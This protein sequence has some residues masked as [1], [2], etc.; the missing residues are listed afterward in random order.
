[1]KHLILLAFLFSAPLLSASSPTEIVTEAFE[2]V[3]G[4]KPD[5]SGMRTFRSRVIEDGWTAVDVRNALKRSDEYANL[6]ITRSFEDVL[7]RKPDQGALKT[8]R[9]KIKRGWTEQDLR[10]VLRNSEEYR[11]RQGG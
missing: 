8:Y 1:M 5:V 9:E 4:R 7:G 3:L 6:V 10:K 11:K 2:D